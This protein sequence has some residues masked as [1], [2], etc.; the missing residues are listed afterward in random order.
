MREFI[1]LKW[2]FKPSLTETNKSNATVWYK[3]EQ[4]TF[5]DCIYVCQSVITCF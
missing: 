1:A 3:L 2:V 4:F 5:N